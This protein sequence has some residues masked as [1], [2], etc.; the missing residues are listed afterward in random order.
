MFT[1]GIIFLSIPIFLFLFTFLSTPFIISSSL[2][3]ASLIFY[4]YRLQ[5]E[6]DSFLSLRLFRKYWPLLLVSF[7]ISYISLSYPFE[8]NDW[9][10]HFAFFNILRENSW[11]PI[12]Y[13]DKQTWFLRHHLAFYLV[14]SLFTKIFGQYFL[15]TA[16]IVWT[17]IGL[18]ITMSLAFHSVQRASH[19][20]IAALV[21]FLFSGLDII[22]V[23]IFYPGYNMELYQ[24][25][26]QWRYGIGQISSN[27]FNITWVPTHTIG[28][29]LGA[30]LFFYN[31]RLAVQYVVMI[32]SIVT[33]WTPFCALGLLPIATWSIFKEGW[34]K[35]LT[36][37]N[38][39]VAPLLAIPIALYA[40][41]G[42]GDIP[43]MFAWQHPEFS[44]VSLIIFYLSEFLLILAAFWY[45]RKKDRDLIIVLGSFL[46]L[47]CL[48]RWGVYSDLVTRASMPAICIMSI[49]MFKSLFENKGWRRKLL[50]VYLLI[51]AI[52]VV[53]AFAKGVSMPWMYRDMALKRYLDQ[54]KPPRG[55]KLD[56][57]ASYY[58]AKTVD[59]RHIFT[60]PLMRG[61]PDDRP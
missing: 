55:S 35:A 39:L 45:L 19:L 18:F 48:I 54:T 14:P 33:L 12:F 57:Y 42:A 43:F 59:V 32:I 50:V 4:L 61:L 53:A 15:I 51:G 44:F 41:Q 26:L 6:H 34:R 49:M 52:P 17:T 23:T 24:G 31:R 1:I 37:Q 2:A 13:F 60:I 47:I 11:P 38:I 7:I 58:L 27:L 22:S 10:K 40:T 25:W 8:S 56:N 16:A 3:L 36:I 21:F 46:S 30:C 20:F 28:G 29:C 9:K 5:L